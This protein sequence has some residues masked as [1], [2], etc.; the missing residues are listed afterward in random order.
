M[1]VG[2]MSAGPG[3]HLGIPMGMAGSGSTRRRWYK[4]IDTGLHSPWAVQSSQDMNRVTRVI[5]R[6]A[7]I[8][9]TCTKERTKTMPRTQFVQEH[10]VHR[11]RCPG[12]QD[13]SIPRLGLPN[14][15]YLRFTGERGMVNNR[16][17][18]RGNLVWFTT[19]S[20]KSSMGKRGP[21]S[22]DTRG[23]RPHFPANC[24]QMPVERSGITRFAQTTKYGKSTAAFG[25]VKTLGSWPW[26]LDSRPARLSA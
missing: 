11:R 7:A 23:Q 21:I 3:R 17:R 26:S 18:W 19:P 9:S 24:H 2:L 15:R 12:S 1:F 10:L 8:Q 16:W 4:P 25:P 13:L 6:P 14:R 20:T 5:T 22:L